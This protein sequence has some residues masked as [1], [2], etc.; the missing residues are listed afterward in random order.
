MGAG[1]AGSRRESEFVPGNFCRYFGTV[2]YTVRCSLACGSALAYPGSSERVINRVCV[3]CWVQTVAHH[4]AARG[5]LR[6]HLGAS[7]AVCLSHRV[8]CEVEDA[9]QSVDSRR[10]CMDITVGVYRLQDN[11]TARRANKVFDIVAEFKYLGG[12]LPNQNFG[13][14]A[15]HLPFVPQSSA[16]V[17]K[18]QYHSRH[19]LTYVLLVQKYAM[20]EFGGVY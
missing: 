8:V 5:G 1:Y 3:A 19:R 4:V 18:Y 2:S 14:D 17:P 10:Y 11:S 20:P 15:S 7:D 16:A 12:K 6:G 9:R 13:H